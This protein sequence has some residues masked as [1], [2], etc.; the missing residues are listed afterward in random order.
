[1]SCINEVEKCG[2][3]RDVQ[4]IINER[5]MPISIELL[6]E[7]N[8]VRDKFNSIKKRDNTGATVLDT[9]AYPVTFSPTDKQKNEAGIRES[10]S[11]IVWT[12]MQNWIDAGIDPNILLSIDSIRT[13]VTVNGID[14][15][16]SDKNMVD[17]MFDSFLYITLGLNR[18]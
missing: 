4:N 16:I 14:Y 9:K 18:K 5:G 8:V 2:A 13:K 1:M 12:A 15:E 7:D 11:V 3:L 17:Q 10:T 6:G